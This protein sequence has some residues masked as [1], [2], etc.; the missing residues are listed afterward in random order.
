MKR[1]SKKIKFSLAGI[2]ATIL[3]YLSSLFTPS[4]T[5]INSTEAKV[6]NIIDGDTLKVLYKNREE[7]VRMLGIDTP[8]SVH[9]D[10]N[11]NTEDGKIASSI[12]KKFLSNKTVKLEFEG[13][14]KDKYGRLLAYVW[15]DNNM[16][17]LKLVSDGYAK[18]FMLKKNSKYYNDFLNAEKDAKLNKKG[19][20]KYTN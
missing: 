10:P 2:I 4:S 1:K 13:D 19:I 7:R 18:V 3:V 11:K 6:L 15:L 16:I 20:W 14:H 17:N 8:E 12:T 5:P 9:P